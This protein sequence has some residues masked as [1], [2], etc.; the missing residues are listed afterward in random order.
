MAIR[1]LSGGILETCILELLPR[2]S[3]RWLRFLY[4]SAMS[5]NIPWTFND[6]FATSCRSF[7]RGHR[8]RQVLI[9][10]DSDYCFSLLSAVYCRDPGNDPPQALLVL[11]TGLEAEPLLCSIRDQNTHAGVSNDAQANQHAGSRSQAEEFPADRSGST[12]Y[13]LLGVPTAIVTLRKPTRR[14]Q[15]SKKVIP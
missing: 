12:A 3:L 15:R 13:M 11:L 8:A 5:R 2:S 1:W 9:A 14:V 4:Y 6:S 7:F 10:F